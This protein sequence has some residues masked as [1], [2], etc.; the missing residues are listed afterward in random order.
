MNNGSAWCITPSFWVAIIRIVETTNC[1]RFFFRR[2]SIFYPLIWRIRNLNEP[3]KL[4][5]KMRSYPLLHF[6]VEN[7]LNFRCTL[8][9]RYW[10]NLANGCDRNR[11]VNWSS[12]WNEYNV[13]NDLRLFDRT[14]NYIFGM[15]IVHVHTTQST[16][17]HTQHSVKV[18][19][20]IGC[21]W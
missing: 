13:Q 16:H 7:R 2:V 11:S 3:E 18:Q 5:H 19:R 21:Q 1:R 6:A 15:C 17:S 10:I 8:N 12:R 14:T 20:R 9:C 4:L